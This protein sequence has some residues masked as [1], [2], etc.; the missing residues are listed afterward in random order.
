VIYAGEHHVTAILEIVVHYGRVALPEP[1][2]ARPIFIPDDLRVE[3]FDPARYPTWQ[4][5]GS[6]GARTYGNGWFTEQRTPVL[7]VPPV[8]GQPAEW[9]VLIKTLHPEA[10]RIQPLGE[11]DV[12]WD[13]RLFGPPTGEVLMQP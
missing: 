10:S 7:L 11:F 2:H 1:H 6:E 3:R 8:V 12:T 9:N 5:E 4:E 13:G